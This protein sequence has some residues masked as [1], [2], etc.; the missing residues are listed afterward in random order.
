[1]PVI[2]A[3]LTSLLCYITAAK[4]VA[5]YR[6]R[7]GGAMVPLISQWY[8]PESI[9]IYLYPIIFAVWATYMSI[10]KPSQEHVILFVTAIFCVTITFLTG[11]ICGMVLPYTYI[12]V[13]P[14]GG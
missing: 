1:M 4:I 11:W 7:T 12:L 13:R 3:S 2:V 5:D 6:F 8:Y 9:M 14:I 10:R